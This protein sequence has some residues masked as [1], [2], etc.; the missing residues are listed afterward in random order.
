[1]QPGRDHAG[2]VDHHDVAGAEHPRQ[3]AH[4]GIA[5]AVAR[6]DEHAR[7]IARPC[8]GLG[9][10]RLGQVEVEIGGAEGF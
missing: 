3:V 5:E 8:G 1:M 7:G 4:P 10:Q 6:D 2:V 9:D